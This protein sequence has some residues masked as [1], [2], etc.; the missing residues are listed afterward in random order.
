MLSMSHGLSYVAVSS[1]YRPSL[2][3]ELLTIFLYADYH[4]DDLGDQSPGSV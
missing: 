3:L 1:E 4:S 2:I